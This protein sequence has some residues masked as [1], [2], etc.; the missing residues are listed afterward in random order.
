MPCRPLLQWVRR[1]HSTL[2][3]PLKAIQLRPSRLQPCTLKAQREV[4]QMPIADK[5]AQVAQAVVSGVA[6]RHGCLLGRGQGQQQ[7][8]CG[9]NSVG[10]FFKSLYK[11]LKHRQVVS[12]GCGAS[13]LCTAAIALALLR[14]EGSMAFINV[15]PMSSSSST[16]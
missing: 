16:R 11:Q 2:Q 3:R 5:I 4:E 7:R 13:R 14:T 15:R 12:R 8:L 1:A 9:H 6:G 10:A